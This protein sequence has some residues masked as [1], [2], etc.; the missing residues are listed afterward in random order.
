ME[1]QDIAQCFSYF[2]NF[3]DQR[4]KR[5]Y[6]AIEALALGRGGI[7]ATSKTSEVS[8]VTITSGCK[9][10]ES[11]A[12]ASKSPTGSAQRIR[13]AGGGR[14]KT[15]DIDSSLKID[16]ESLIEPVTRGYSE[17][18]LRWTAK[19]V[20]KLSKEFKEQG[21]KTSHRMVVELLKEMG[22]SLQTNRKTSECK[23]FVQP[24]LG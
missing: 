9:E 10:L 1:S 23:I 15:V 21:Y 13:L 8:R 4:Q 6:L 19:I 14:K 17:S 16:L 7:T 18:L 22:Y 24:R 12:S 2:K 5:L 20:C 11:I 3:L